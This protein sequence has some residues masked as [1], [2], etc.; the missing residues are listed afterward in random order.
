[1]STR[2][3]VAAVFRPAVPHDVPDIVTLVNSAYRGEPSRVGWAT[4]ADLLGG[5]APATS[6]FNNL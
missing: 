2:P 4:E 5:S 3:P 6:L 1:V